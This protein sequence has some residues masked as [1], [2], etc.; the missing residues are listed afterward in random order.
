MCLGVC[1][2]V[3]TNASNEYFIGLLSV[4]LGQP[5]DR[6]S[7]RWLAFRQQRL[8]KT[9]PAASLE[10]QWMKCEF[11]SNQSTIK[12]TSDRL[13]R[14]QNLALRSNPLVSS[15]PLFDLSKREKV[16]DCIITAEKERK[17]EHR[18]L[19]YAT[20]T[21]LLVRLFYLTTLSV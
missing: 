9:L 16:C 4:P 18:K 19:D 8:R 14:K 20:L 2:C 7:C 17:Q 15:G 6:A 21:L 11:T 5:A 12:I 10:W 1:V 3:C 13:H